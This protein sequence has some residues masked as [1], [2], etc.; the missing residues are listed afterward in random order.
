MLNFYNNFFWGNIGPKT[1]ENRG[2]VSVLRNTNNILLSLSKIVCSLC[3]NKYFYPIVYP[4]INNLSKNSRMSSK[5]RVRIYIIYLEISIIIL[6][7]R[8]KFKRK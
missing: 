4:I 7:I 3:E 1:R 8:G 5:Q 2:K 6:N